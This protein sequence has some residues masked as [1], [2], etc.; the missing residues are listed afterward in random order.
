LAVADERRP[1]RE[2]MLAESWTDW[3]K[4]FGHRRTD[5]TLP[6]DS[7]MTVDAYDRRLDTYFVRESIKRKNEKVDLE[8][9]TREEYTLNWS[10]SKVFRVVLWLN[11]FLCVFE[12][13]SLITCAV[14]DIVFV[15]Y[16]R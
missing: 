5:Y 9:I 4:Y 2:I 16:I 12:L 14:Y 11:K 15:W 3:L 1:S 7:I 8:K 6:S 10:Q 13:S